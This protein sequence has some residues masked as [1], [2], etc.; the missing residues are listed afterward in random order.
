MA[1]TDPHHGAHAHDNPAVG[2]ETTDASLGGVERF[3]VVTI[4]FL[5]I[6]FG[7]MWLMYSYFWGRENA[8]DVQ[9]SPVIPREG[10]RMPPLPRL[11]TRP[12]QDLATLRGTQQQVL[13]VWEWVDRERG[14]ARIPVSRALE[15]VAERGVPT[16]PASAAA[17]A[18][19]AAVQAHAEHGHVVGQ[20]AAGSPPAAAAGGAAG[21]FNWTFPAAG[22]GGSQWT[23]PDGTTGGDRPGATAPTTRP[24]ETPGTGATGRPGPQ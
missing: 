2:H 14:I 16:P 22:A 5:A 21:G 23:A 10:D 11:Q 24:H 7:L 6:A 15:I 1:H 19:A 18:M 3:M 13:D 9:P 4:L 12:E 20:P 8:L 17:A